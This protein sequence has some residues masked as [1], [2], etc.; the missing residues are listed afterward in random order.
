[1]V[2]VGALESNARAATLVWRAATFLPQIF[3]GIGTFLYWLRRRSK[4]TLG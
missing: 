4:A 1:M 3:V 2:A